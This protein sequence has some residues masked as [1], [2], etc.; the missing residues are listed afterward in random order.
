[1]VG[2]DCVTVDRLA[3]LSNHSSLLEHVLVL[4]LPILQQHVLD[5]HYRGGHIGASFL[6]AW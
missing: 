4:S 3:S 1:M 5:I 2:G 6:A